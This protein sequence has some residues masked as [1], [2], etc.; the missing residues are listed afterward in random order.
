MVTN[1]E[2][3]KLLAVILVMHL[4]GC[5][6]SW[7]LQLILLNFH[8]SECDHIVGKVFAFPGA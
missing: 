8:P 2:A 6:G 5:F 1:S 7:L 3:L 4:S